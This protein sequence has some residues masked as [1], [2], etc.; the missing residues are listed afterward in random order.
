MRLRQIFQHRL[1]WHLLVGAPLI[2][3][4]LLTTGCSTGFI[5]NRLDTLASWY[6][7]SL[8]SLNDGQRTELRQWLSS[9][10]A[11]HRRTELTRYAS[12][13]NEVY[14]TAEQP[15]DAQRY[16]EMRERFQGLLNNLIEKTAPEASQLLMHLSPQQVEELLQNLEEKTR[17]STEEGAEA[18]ADNEWRPEQVK[19][20]SKQLKRWTGAV[21]AEQRTIIATHVAKLE[22]TFEDWAESQEAW[23]EA[24]RNALLTQPAKSEQVPPR[25]L[26]LLADPDEQWTSAYAEKVARNRLRYQEMLLALD[27][28]LMPKQREHLRREV[29]NLSQQLTRLAST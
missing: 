6:F 26:Q 20:I 29:L 7:E 8:V 2:L 27:A 24:L 19:D 11:W 25:V 3:C 15:G 14:T 9:T 10:L 28:S 5:Y 1:R 16:D 13:L 23:R 4:A 21:T 17:E 22:P 12:L 18:V